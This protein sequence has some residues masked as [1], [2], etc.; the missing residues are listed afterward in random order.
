MC[1]CTNVSH[2]RS[3]SVNI[4]ILE[5]YTAPTDSDMCQTLTKS[6]FLGAGEMAQQGTPLAALARDPG[7]VPNTHVVVHNWS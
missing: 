5:S 7:L 3:V 4:Q 1:I 6:T 2:L